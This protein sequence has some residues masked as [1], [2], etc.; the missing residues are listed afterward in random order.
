M[1]S[2]GRGGLVIAL[3]GV[4]EG[5]VGLVALFPVKNELKVNGQLLQEFIALFQCK[6]HDELYASRRI[7]QIYEQGR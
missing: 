3:S 4:M 6:Q 2:T 7:Y 5:G 1:Y